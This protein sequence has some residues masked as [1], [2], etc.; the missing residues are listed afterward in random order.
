MSEKIDR[1]GELAAGA[2]ESFSISQGTR[3]IKNVTA[4]L[5]WVDETQRPG[6]PRLRRYENLPDSFTMSVTPPGGNGSEQSAANPAGGEG[7]IEIS[8]SV[9]NEDLNS[10]IGDAIV[11]GTLL[12]DW[13]AEVVLTDA[14]D[15]RTV[16]P[17]RFIGFRD[18]AN[19]YILEMTI[20]YYDISGLMAV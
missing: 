14:G 12:P 7:R 16:L 9:S 19:S 2:N 5:T 11:S 13:S 17:P 18:D 8:L 3:I 6:V 1:S 4:V 15:W 20:E 10:A